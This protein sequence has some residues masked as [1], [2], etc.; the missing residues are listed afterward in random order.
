MSASNLSH[1]LYPD[2]MTPDGLARLATDSRLPDF[3]RP[4]VR[5]IPLAIVVDDAELLQAS[6]VAYDS[7]TAWINT[8]PVQTESAPTAAAPCSY[9]PRGSYRS[10]S[11]GPERFVHL[12]G[13]TYYRS[14]QGKLWDT[15]STPP[16]PCRKCKGLHWNFTPCYSTSSSTS[17]PNPSAGA[18]GPH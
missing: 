9:L 12:N 5:L 14:N 18:S 4:L 3:V 17:L 6:K 15:A 2:D 16:Y 8:Q 13:R 10:R 11:P 1:T 7:V